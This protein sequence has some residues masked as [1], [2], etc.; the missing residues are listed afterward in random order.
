MRSLILGLYINNTIICT[1]LL[2]RNKEFYLIMAH[3]IHFSNKHQ[4]PSKRELESVILGYKS[5]VNN[6]INNMLIVCSHIYPIENKVS[7]FI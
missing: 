7:K 2:E 4:R 3:H 6:M 1:L 5:S